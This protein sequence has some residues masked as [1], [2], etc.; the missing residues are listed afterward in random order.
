M[1]A[2]DERRKVVQEEFARDLFREALSKIAALAESTVTMRAAAVSHAVA[3][4]PPRA[5]DSYA[6][7][8]RRGYVE[9]YIPEMRAWLDDVERILTSDEGADG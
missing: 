4:A 7:N 8:A 1:M 2:E 6:E 9:R 3:S 5:W